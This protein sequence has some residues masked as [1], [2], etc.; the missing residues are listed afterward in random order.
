[1]KTKYCDVTT[2]NVPKHPDNKAYER[3]GCKTVCSLNLGYRTG[4]VVN[5]MLW[6]FYLQIKIIITHLAGS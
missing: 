2:E 4:R 3:N 5:F 6:P 1:M